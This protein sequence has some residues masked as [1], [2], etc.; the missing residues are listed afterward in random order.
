MLSVH[1]HACVVL[2]LTSITILPMDVRSLPT[3]N[4]MYTSGLG[5][6][7]GASSGLVR[8]DAAAA[9]GASRERFLSCWRGDADAVTV[10]V[11]RVRFLSCWRDAGVASR[12]RF[13][14]LLR[15]EDA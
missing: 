3:P 12:E 6:P 14:V 7:S 10:V 1:V 9:G 2:L 11:S 15:D 5:G 8:I 4:S 13:L